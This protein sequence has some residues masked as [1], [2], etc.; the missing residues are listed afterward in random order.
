MPAEAG[1]WKVR[2]PPAVRRG[3]PTAAT[4]NSTHLTVAG[5]SRHQAA[6]WSFVEFALTRPAS[7][8]RFY[9]GKGIAPALMK[10]YGDAVF[11]EPSAYFSGQRKGEIFLAALKAPSPAVN[12]TSD[13]ARALELVT[14]AQ[15]KVLLKGADPAKVLRAAADELARQTGRKAQHAALFRLPGG[16]DRQPGAHPGHLA[17]RGG[18]GRALRHGDA[19]GRCDG[20]DGGPADDRGA[21]RGAADLRTPGRGPAGAS[22]GGA[23][24]ARVVAPPP[25]AAARRP[26]R[27]GAA[28]RAVPAGDGG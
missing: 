12:Y 3:G 5:S 20:R 25:R 4:V 15:S 23:F 22:G 10:S 1:K 9:P 13:Y 6:A 24:L 11:H 2:L 18:C 28:G 27:A 21:A 14:D 17:A 8:L 7:Q 26:G 19:V 16:R